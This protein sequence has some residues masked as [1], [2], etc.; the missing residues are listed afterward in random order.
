[1]AELLT[2]WPSDYPE[3]MRGAQRR[4]LVGQLQQVGKLL[5]SSHGNI[6]CQDMLAHPS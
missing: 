1:V 6:L 2:A 5:R 3:S 4:A